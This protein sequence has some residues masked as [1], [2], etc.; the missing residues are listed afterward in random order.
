MT[1][2]TE[3][4]LEQ[5]INELVDRMIEITSE[6]ERVGGDRYGEAEIHFD[7]NDKTRLELREEITDWLSSSFF[8]WKHKK[9][10]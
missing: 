5:K 7:D 3:E 10:V 4:I 9:G 6:H 1:N 8:I 2:L